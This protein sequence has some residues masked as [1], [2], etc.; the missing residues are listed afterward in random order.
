MIDL[1][2]HLLTLP[3]TS[4]IKFLEESTEAYNSCM[5]K[6]MIVNCTPIAKWIVNRVLSFMPDESTR[7][8]SIYTKEELMEGQLM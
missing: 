7:K 5:E 3:F 8:V 1:D 4:L 6:I 2:E